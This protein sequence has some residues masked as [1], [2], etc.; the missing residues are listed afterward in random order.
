MKKAFLT[1]VVLA[2]MI[3]AAHTKESVKAFIADAAKIE[4]EAFTQGARAYFNRQCPRTR[5]EGEDD[6]DNRWQHGYDAAAEFDHNRHY[7]G[8]SVCF[9]F[10]SH[11]H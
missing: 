9:H 2:A 10:L 6:P 5:L 8:D 1:G 7:V 3:T 11:R 4:G